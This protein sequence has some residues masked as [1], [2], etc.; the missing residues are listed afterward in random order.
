MAPYIALNRL[1]HYEV[2]IGVADVLEDVTDICRSTSDTIERCLVPPKSGTVF[3]TASVRTNHIQAMP[4]IL[5]SSIHFVV[6]APR[7]GPIYYGRMATVTL[8]LACKDY[9]ARK[10]V[11]AV[12]NMYQLI[13]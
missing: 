9:L 7:T 2:G 12:S 4:G 3:P 1:A 13:R 5:L 10:K 11:D 8:A 6:P